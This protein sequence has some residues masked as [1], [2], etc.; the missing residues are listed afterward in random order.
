MAIKATIHKAEL[1]LS[2][3]DRNIYGDYPI[4]L[5]RHPSETDERMLIRLLVFALNLPE[6][7]GNST[8]EFAKD[9]W[10]ADEPA[11]W[12]KDLTGR[13][14]HWMEVGQPDDKRLLRAASR[15]DRVSVFSYSSSSEIWWQGIA[16]KLTR[17]RNL[18]VWQIPAQQSESLAMLCQRSME[19]QVTV[20]DGD[21]WVGDG[22]RSIQVAPVRL[23]GPAGAGNSV[24]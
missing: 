23:C 3:I 17:A 6:D 5:A 16:P 4:T 11:L 18:T 22:T 13:T 15:V 12:Q 7:G 9:L 1:Q 24:R 20:Q 21:I 19:L 2:D 8:L 10:D 14:I